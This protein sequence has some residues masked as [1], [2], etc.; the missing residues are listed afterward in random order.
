MGN[1]KIAKQL[2]VTPLGLEILSR[3]VAGSKLT[4]PRNPGS[5]C[6]R[7]TAQGHLLPRTQENGW[8][9]EITETGREIVRRAREMG[10]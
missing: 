9:R 10:W 3:R 6:D 1:Q 4:G 7:L 2:G 5:A 8:Q